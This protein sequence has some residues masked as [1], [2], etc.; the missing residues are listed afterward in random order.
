MTVLETSQRLRGAQ[1]KVLRLQR[2][3]WLAELALWPAAIV[4][5]VLVLGTGWL[6][7]RR[8]AVRADG[9]RPGPKDPPREDAP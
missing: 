2:R 3:V 9:P 5:A 7:W 4:L 6:L 8:S 1:R